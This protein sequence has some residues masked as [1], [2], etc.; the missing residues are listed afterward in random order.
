MVCPTCG[1][2]QGS[3][4]AICRTCNRINW[5]VST[6]KL[7][8]HQEAAALQVLRDCAGGLQDLVETSGLDRTTEIGP[9][10][11]SGSLAEREETPEKCEEKKKKKKRKNVDNDKEDSK[12]KH[13]SKT[14]D[15]K[16][17]KRR[18]AKKEQSGSQEAAEDPPPAG[19]E[20]K[21]KPSEG[22]I[23]S[24][25]EETSPPNPGGR[26]SGSGLVRTPPVAEDLQSRVDAYASSNPRSFELGT[27]PRRE[28]RDHGE[29]GET[30]D[31]RDLRRP[32]EPA[33]PPAGFSSR[34]RGD[35]ESEEIPRRPVPAPKKN[36]GRA[37]RERGKIYGRRRQ[38]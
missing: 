29:G 22:E 20:K 28:R 12:H 2:F 3:P 32:A 4:C 21:A 26:S 8:V 25:V 14:K 36:K 24:D 27:L 17:R 34:R 37:H 7:A 31:D 10:D 18:E 35:E 19:K 9:G 15:K 11:E 5:L 6:G 1:T 38:R 33:H 23:V 30:A 13:K 16:D